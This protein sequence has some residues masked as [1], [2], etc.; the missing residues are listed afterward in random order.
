MQRHGSERSKGGSMSKY[1]VA[2]VAPVV[3]IL[4]DDQAFSLCLCR[5]LE[6]YGFQVQEF[7]ESRTLLE[8]AENAPPDL[9]IID[10]NLA[11]LG[12]GFS[13][14]KKL[15]KRL[16]AHCPLLVVSSTSDPTAFLKALEVGA[17]DYL[18]KPLAYPLLANTLARY[19]DSSMMQ[20]ETTSVLPVTCEVT[21]ADLSLEFEVQ[22]INETGLTLSGRHLIAKDARISL[23]GFFLEELSGCAQPQ[24]ATLVDAVYDAGSKTYEYTLVFDPD[25][26]SF[27]TS[28]RR[29]L[30]Q[31]EA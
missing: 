9:A 22:D 29:W 6:K 5:V 10:L 1:S 15:R 27:L 3:M 8:A 28:V 21:H 31:K 24:V 23:Q 19:F 18:V 11:E 30:L 2:P 12:E 7:H 4:D 16:G 20:M 26:I 25:N 17:N 13:V 14:V